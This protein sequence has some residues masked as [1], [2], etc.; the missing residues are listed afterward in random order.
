M[1]QK[2]NGDFD[3]K[4]KRGETYSGIFRAEKQRFV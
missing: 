2:K 3:E 1:Q 4:E